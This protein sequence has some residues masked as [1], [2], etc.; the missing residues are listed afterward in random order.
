MRKE[1][2]C[3]IYSLTSPSGKMYIGQSVD[4]KD[5]LRKYKFVQCKEQPKIY[6]SLLK[7]G[8]VSF[9]FKIERICLKENLNYFEMK[10]IKIYE[11]QLNCTFGGENG[12]GIGEKHHNWKGGISLEIDYN[13]TY[14]KEWREINKEQVKIKQKENYQINKEKIAERDKNYRL[15]NK[16]LIKKRKHDSR[17]INAEL[18]SLKTK[19]YRLKNLEKIRLKDRERYQKR[20]LEKEQK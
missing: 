6:N 10:M 1:K 11:P 16:E 2:I 12:F 5:R 13:K 18:I 9:I 8:F 4:I 7:Y 14:A 15:K 19:E 20:K 3:G 17:I